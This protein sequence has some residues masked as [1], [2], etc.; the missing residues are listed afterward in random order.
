[1][2][3]APGAQK[4]STQMNVELMSSQKFL[5]GTRTELSRIRTP[6]DGGVHA[7]LLPEVLGPLQAGAGRANV[8]SSVPYHCNK[9]CFDVVSTTVMWL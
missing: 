8:M 2:L 1:M 4:L 3:P 6:H 9:S 5:D 7:R